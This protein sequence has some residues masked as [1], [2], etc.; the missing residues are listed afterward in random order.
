MKLQEFLFRILQI[1][2]KQQIL[3]KGVHCKLECTAVGPIA[4]LSLPGGQ[5]KPFSQSFFNFL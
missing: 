1:A 2:L 5:D 3:G 4:S